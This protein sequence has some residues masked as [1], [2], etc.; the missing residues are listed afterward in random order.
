M[1]IIIYKKTQKNKKNDLIGMKNSIKDGDNKKFITIFIANFY[2]LFLLPELSKRC[3]SMTLSLK[4][5][6]IN[7]L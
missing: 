6:P 2:S 5:N 7:C 1:D 3:H 4:K